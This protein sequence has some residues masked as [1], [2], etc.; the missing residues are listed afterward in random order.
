M[1]RILPAVLL[2]AGM[3][4]FDR[5]SRFRCRAA[6][7]WVSARRSISSSALSCRSALGS[8][9]C[10]EMAATVWGWYSITFIQLFRRLEASKFARAPTARPALRDPQS[11][12]GTALARPVPLPRISRRPDPISHYRGTQSMSRMYIPGRVQAGEAGRGRPAYEMHGMLWA[13]FAA[14]PPSPL[15]KWRGPVLR[16][17][18]IQN[19]MSVSV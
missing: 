9:W 5:I 19:A 12:I 14:Y 4:C 1:T 2:A 10:W 17:N 16:I 11:R 8:S 6:A 15:K 3:P 13:W 18:A 7:T